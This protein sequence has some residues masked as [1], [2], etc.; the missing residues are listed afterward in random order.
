MID[1]NCSSSQSGLSLT[2]QLEVLLFVAPDAVFPGQ[3]ANALDVS[4]RQV[5]KGLEKLK[6]LYHNR[7]LRL[8]WHDG[9]V[10]LTTPPEAGDLVERF[11]R[12]ESTT[13]LSQAALETLAIVAYKQPV[14][15]PQVDAIRGVNSDGVLRTLLSKG[16]IE[17]AGR[18]EGPGRPILYC[19]TSDFLRYFGLSSLEDLPPLEIKAELTNNDQLN[20]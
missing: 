10:Q 3:L 8:L 14:T 7:G 9:K 16:L 17:E 2:A 19:S 6:H 20:G 1:Q 5:E 4:T 11:L 18:A 13:R 15:R 12:I